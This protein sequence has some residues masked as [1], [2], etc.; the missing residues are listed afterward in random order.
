[1]PV[2]GSVRDILIRDLGPIADRLELYAKAAELPVSNKMEADQMAAVCAEIKADI[3]TVKGHEILSKIKKGLDGLHKKW[4]G[5]E[6]MFL[7]PAER[8]Y[9]IAK[10]KIMDWED[11][12]ARIAEE[13]RLKAQAV[14]DAKA[15]KERE[16]QEAEARKQREAEAEARRK[17]DEARR[18]AEAA[19]DEERKRLAA[20][21]EAADR[22]ANAAA[23]KA[24]AKEAAADTV[25]T[26]TIHVEART[27]G[28]RKA[29]AWKIKSIDS[30][31]FF[32]ALGRRQDLR[33][34]VDINTTRMER[35]KA[36]NTAIDIPG[37][38]I[39]QIN[40]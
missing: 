14:A 6:K 34:Y 7:V 33:G 37:V 30:D 22:R 32:A 23:R 1:V 27:T 19:S 36:A 35:S 13:I 9:K 40:R 25:I 4:T 11:E 20:E 15:A 38:V 26:P 8:D 29:K 31:I 2:A 24:E 12:E 18:E 17:A 10:Q 3:K 28:I 5:L 16:K 21:A 39:E